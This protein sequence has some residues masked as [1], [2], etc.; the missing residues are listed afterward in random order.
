M[1]KEHVDNNFRPL[2]QE[3]AQTLVQLKDE[4]VSVLTDSEAAVEA[5]NPEAI[6]MLRRRCDGIK[7]ELSRRSHDVYDRISNGD[8]ANLTV[9]YVYLNLLQESQEL[10]TSLRKMLRAA[11]KLN[12]AP[13]VYRSFSAT[14]SEKT[15]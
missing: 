3:L 10:V 5:D 1:C 7:A 13:K 15:L 14:S 2:P 11:G 12:L 9:T 8:A 4:I 6:D